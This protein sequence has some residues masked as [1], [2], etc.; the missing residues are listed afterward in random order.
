MS[1]VCVPVVWLQYR[2]SCS[3]PPTEHLPNSPAHYAI[4]EGLGPTEMTASTMHTRSV[5]PIIIASL[6]V[7][8]GA[9]LAKYESYHD[10]K[11]QN[12]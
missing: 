9:F 12:T 11:A 4:L 2:T 5:M 3:S 7:I 10:P 1:A 8:F 6:L